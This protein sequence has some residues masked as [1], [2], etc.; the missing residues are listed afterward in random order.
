[1][2]SFV[3]LVFSTWLLD[4]P[5]SDDC[6]MRLL[7]GMMLNP[8]TLSW[9]WTTDTSVN[10]ALHAVKNEDY[11]DEEVMQVWRHAKCPWSSSSGRKYERPLKWCAP[12]S[13]CSRFEPLTLHN[14]YLLH[15]STTTVHL[16]CGS[17][18]FMCMFELYWVE[19]DCGTP[20]WR[21]QGRPI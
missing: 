11:R 15:T 2:F 6:Q 17:E 20:A 13:S 19:T 14:W 1:M 10:Y 18:S 12:S 7:H 21:S 16:E 5:V 4:V 3:S 9:C 8:L